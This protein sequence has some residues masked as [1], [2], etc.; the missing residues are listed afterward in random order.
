MRLAKLV[1]LALACGASALPVI[2]LPCFGHISLDS[3]VGY[4]GSID[5]LAEE[6]TIYK[7]LKDD[8]Q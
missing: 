7:V 2:T 6:K 4:L 5:D 1:P 8:T 3:L